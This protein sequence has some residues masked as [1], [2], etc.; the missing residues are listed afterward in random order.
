MGLKKIIPKKIRNL[1]HLPYAYFGAQKYGNPSEKMFVIG[2]TG[3]SGKSTTICFLRQILEHAGYTV[4]SLSTIDFYIAGHNKLNDKKMT[5][6]GKSQIQKYL[7][8][9]AD[10]GCDVAIVEVTSEGYLQYRHKY[11]NFDAI[12]LTNLY[13]EHIDSHGSFANYKAAKLGIFKYVSHCKHKYRLKKYKKIA[14][15][16]VVEN[17]KELCEKV[18]KV[19]V[20]NA[21]VSQ[22]NEF[23][24][25]DF[26][27]KLFFGKRDEKVFLDKENRKEV[28]YKFCSKN[29]EVSHDGLTFGINGT[30]YFAPIYGEHNIG[31]ILAALSVAEFLTIE[32]DLILQ[33]IASLE[34]PAGRL[35]FIKEGEKAGFQVIVDYA[36]EPIAMEKLYDVV[37]KIAPKR[38]IHVCGSTGG[39]RDKSRRS[40][41]GKMIGEMADIFIVTDEDPYN[42]DPMEIIKEVS[43][44]AQ[45]VGKKINQ[46]LFEILDRKKAI[47]K[48]IKMAQ[49]GDLILVTGKGSEQKMCVAGGKMIDWDDREIVRKAIEHKT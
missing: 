4:G 39:G 32:K 45:K 7:G 49:A 10:A 19:A 13:P 11:I 47:K 22:L 26:D 41:L 46:D 28:E 9:M 6:L 44:S 20:L 12:I 5:M 25:F 17:P 29:I 23:L 31:N 34:S 18:E 40:K 8:E 42:D 24:Q 15:C 21:N 16:D 27:Q 33:A 43:D 48:A 38:I 37:E 3:T 1:V 2:V 14:I 35:E 36:F 30:K